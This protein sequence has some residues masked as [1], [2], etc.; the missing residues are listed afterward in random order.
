MVS[1]RNV[2]DL[3]KAQNRDTKLHLILFDMIE[4][5]A[6]RSMRELPY[7]QR[8]QAMFD[9]FEPKVYMDRTPEEEPPIILVPTILLYDKKEAENYFHKCVMDGFFQSL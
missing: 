7:E 2:Y 1:G 4:D 3:K 8:I 5:D 6:G 9:V